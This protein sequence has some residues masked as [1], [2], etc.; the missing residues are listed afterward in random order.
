MADCAHLLADCDERR[1]TAPNAPRPGDGELETSTPPREDEGKRR[2]FSSELGTTG[3]ACSR[4]GSDECADDDCAAM[5]RSSSGCSASS[6]DTH[7]E[8]A[9]E[10]EA[11][12]NPLAPGLEQLL[13]SN[14][15]VWGQRLVQLQP[16]VYMTEHLMEC[17]MY[18]FKYLRSLQ[19]EAACMGQFPVDYLARQDM[20]LHD[21]IACWWIALKHASVRT[22]VPNRTLM[23]R[24]TEA[25]PVLLNDRE[26]AALIAI[27]W[28]VQAVLKKG[29][30]VL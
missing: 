29:G 24:A 10:A 25:V 22:A 2:R 27:D 18:L 12:P 15:A 3:G 19:V 20:M 8:D 14:L 21:L 4:C 17:G 16:K 11:E 13:R 9:A 6:S 7:L 5:S 26:L 1:V 23:C 30:L 28:E